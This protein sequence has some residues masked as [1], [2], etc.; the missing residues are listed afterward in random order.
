MKQQEQQR[1]RPRRLT[2]RRIRDL[3]SR[4]DDGRLSPASIL[5]FE[6]G[7]S[8]RKKAPAERPAFADD[9]TAASWNPAGLV[10]LER[11]EISAVW[12]WQ[13]VENDNRSL[14]PSFTPE[15]ALIAGR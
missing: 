9:A 8:L 2:V 15:D 11:P 7:E 4:L 6:L 3:A 5:G 1:S 12:R 13:Q 14:D 10:R